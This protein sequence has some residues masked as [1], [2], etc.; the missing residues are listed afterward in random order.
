[1]TLLLCVII[2]QRQAEAAAWGPRYNWAP[3]I[4]AALANNLDEYKRLLNQV[5]ADAFGRYGE[6]RLGM[7]SLLICV[8]SQDGFALVHLLAECSVKLDCNERSAVK[9]RFGIAFLRTTLA[10]ARV[11]QFV[12]LPDGLVRVAFGMHA[13]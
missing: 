12:N 8:F 6:V 2:L 4:N 5:P 7:L 13:L 3:L 11:V 10:D 9:P 1:M